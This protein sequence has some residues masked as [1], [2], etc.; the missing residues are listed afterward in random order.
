[1]RL[2]AEL[3]CLLY[4]KIQ[5]SFLLSLARRGKSIKDEELLALSNTINEHSK[6]STE[7]FRRNVIL[8]LLSLLKFLK[9]FR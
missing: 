7:G 2:T 1:M 9:K 3:E 5:A 4:S 6:R 8:R